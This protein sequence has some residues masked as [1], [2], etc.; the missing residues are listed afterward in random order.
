MDFNKKRIDKNKSLE[1][2]RQKLT[3]LDVLMRNS[4]MN[5]NLTKIDNSIIKKYSRSNPFT[6]INNTICN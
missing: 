3:E 1:V 2:L 4:A 5:G 6:S